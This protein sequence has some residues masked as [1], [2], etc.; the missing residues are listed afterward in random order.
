MSFQLDSADKLLLKT[1]QEETRV[2]SGR[3]LSMIDPS[4]NVL[5]EIVNLFL[6]PLISAWTDTANASNP[7]D[8]PPLQVNAIHHFIRTLACLLFYKKTPSSF[9][10]NESAFPPASQLNGPFFSRVTKG[11]SKPGEDDVRSV[12]GKPHRTCPNVS[13]CE[14]MCNEVN[15]KFAFVPN[16][17]MLSQDDDQCRLSSLACEDIGLVRVN[18]PKKAFGPVATGS[19]SVTSGITLSI[20]VA[21]RGESALD[22]TKIVMMNLT[23]AQLPDQVQGS[24]IIA[25]DRGYWNAELIQCLS[26]CG[27]QLIGTHK[28]TKAYPFTFGESRACD[29]QKRVEEKG[30]KS[31]CWARKKLGNVD[32]HALA[33]RD[34]KGNVATM[35]TT[36]RDIPFYSFNCIEKRGTTIRVSSTVNEMKN[37]VTELTHG[38]GGVDWHVMRS[39]SGAITS[40]TASIIFRYCQDDIPEESRCLLQHL[41]IREISQSTEPAFT[42]EVLQEKTIPQLKDILRQKQLP[43]TGSKPTL[44]NRILDAPLDQLDIRQELMKTW[45][46]KPLKN[47]SNFK[48][49][50]LNEDRIADNICRFVNDNNAKYSI[51]DISE[52]GLVS[53]NDHEHLH[54]SADRLCW[55]NIQP[56]N[57]AG[58]TQREFA[59]IEMKTVTKSTT[60]DQAMNRIR[61]YLAGERVIQVNFE[62]LQF[63]SLVWTPGY[64]GQVL[65]HA[66]VYRSNYVVFACANA[67]KIH[68]VLVVFI[69]NEILDKYEI[70]TTIMHQRRLEWYSEPVST[71]DGELNLHHAI[72]GHTM[73]LWKGMAGELKVFLA[74]NSEV[75]PAHDLRP[76]IVDLWNRFK[77]GQDVVSRQMSNVKVNFR[78]LSP[79]AF[80][81]IRQIM[82]QLLNAHLALRLVK[83]QLDDKVD[84]FTSYKKMKQALNEMGTFSDF[85]YKFGENWEPEKNNN[86]DMDESFGPNSSAPFPT[87]VPK[88]NRVSWFNSFEGGKRLRLSTEGHA[89]LQAVHPKKKCLLCDMKTTSKCEKC[90]VHL[91]RFTFGQHRT[92]CWV[93]HHTRQKIEKINR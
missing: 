29:E 74:N 50:L 25:M 86:D 15:S 91:C 71:Y 42:E 44:I 88:R 21:H 8:A 70:A 18:N 40:T 47:N 43:I 90:Q 5:N 33:H 14:R 24:N 80:L 61:P 55:L 62:S 63:K 58:P 20:H 27:F 23:N 37:R 66:A 16:V 77:G 54:T 56:H 22:V 10:G 9:F 69:S 4:K 11:F 79:R 93:K 6:S 51:Q 72:D 75:N 73:Q 68:Y 57:G 52:C 64:R 41:G 85:L 34:G 1:L 28:R 65:H 36:I 31:L 32:M 49:G 26:N 87:S 67:F 30:A 39:T 3:I 19:V 83:L 84:E 46:M 17:S 2:I 35:F 45:F 53:N 48:I 89:L 92:S 13:R 81:V 76:H 59:P 82:T 60:D 78:Q 38:Q 12:W 7:T